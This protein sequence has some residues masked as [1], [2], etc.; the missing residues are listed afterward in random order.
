[1]SVVLLYCFEEFRSWHFKGSIPANKSAIYVFAGFSAVSRDTLSVTHLLNTVERPVCD[2]S[3]SR[4]RHL[5]EKRDFLVG[6]R[7]GPCGFVRV[8]GRNTEL[9][10]P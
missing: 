7:V 10:S 6:P 8:E 4:V 1:M 3:Y 2:M 5:S 9:E